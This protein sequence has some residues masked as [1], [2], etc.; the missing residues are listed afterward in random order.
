VLTSLGIVA[1]D[2]GDRDLRMTLYQEALACYQ[3]A[4]DVRSTALQ[5]L[6]LAET[7][8]EQEDMAGTLGP[9]DESIA[10]F[11]ELGDPHGLAYALANRG[12]LASSTG[13]MDEAVSLLAESL[14]L[15]QDIGDK[16]G[17]PMCLVGLAG[18]AAME[19]DATRAARLFSAAEALGKLL[20]A[21]LPVVYRREY[22]RHLGAVRAALGEEALAAAWAA[23]RA[24]SLEQ[25]IAA[26]LAR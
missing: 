11:R 21:A 24:L 8:M 12:L 25:A 18:V 20:G 5:L 1:G 2:L 22:E 9:L 15:R 23:G 26:A 10:V 13:A 16:A 6:N 3:A 4:G 14:A 7:L 19:G 17:V